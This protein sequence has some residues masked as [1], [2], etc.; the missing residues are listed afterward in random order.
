MSVDSAEE[1]IP[2]V[3]VA[4]IRQGQFGP[5]LLAARRIEPPDL[6]GGWELP[7]GKVEP[8]ESAEEAAHREIDEELGVD[9]VLGRQVSGPLDGSWA[10]G[11]RHTMDVFIAAVADGQEPQ[12]LQQHDAIRWLPL[13]DWAEVPWLAGD[14]G[15][16]LAIVE[17]LS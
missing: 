12:A 10:L 5:E 15:P 7:G 6:A 4:L 8:G 1:P 14:V 17:L 3:G 2:V 11:E 16:V 9:I 13:A